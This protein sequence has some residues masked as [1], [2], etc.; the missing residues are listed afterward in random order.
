MLFFTKRISIELSSRDILLNKFSI[1][2]NVL[3][4]LKQSEIVTKSLFPGVYRKQE[5][6]FDD[7]VAGNKLVLAF[8]IL[9]RSASDQPS[10]PTSPIVIHRR[11][12]AAEVGIFSKGKIK[13]N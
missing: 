7:N 9:Q 11:D 2:K 10:H 4:K 1:H 8:R 5:P 12:L 3:Q 6:R 13:E